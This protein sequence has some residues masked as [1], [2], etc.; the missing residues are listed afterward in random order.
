M[1]KQKTVFMTATLDTK[2]PEA[3]FLK[4]LIEER[5]LRT[6]VMDIGTTGKSLFGEAFQVM[7]SIRSNCLFSFD[8][9]AHFCYRNDTRR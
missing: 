1:S 3:L 9:L 2:G 7:C 6:R 5:R 8:P 4:R